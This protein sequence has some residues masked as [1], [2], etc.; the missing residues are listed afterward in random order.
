MSALREEAVE[1]VRRLE[2]FNQDLRFAIAGHPGL[3]HQDPGRL[4][5]GKKDVVMGGIFVVGK[6]LRGQRAPE[7]V[8]AAGG[9]MDCA[10]DFF[11]LDIAAG[12][13]EDLRAEAELAE[14]AGHRV[15]GKLFIMGGDS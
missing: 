1:I 15:G 7:M 12:E 10:A 13:G 3:G 5:R 8:A 14:L 11:I 9:D 4:L 6:I 2:I